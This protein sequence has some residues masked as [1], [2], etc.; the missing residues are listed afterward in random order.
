[1]ADILSEGTNGDPVAINHA[2]FDTLLADHQLYH[3]DLQMDSFITGRNG[4]TVYGCYKQALRELFKRYRGLK[5][6][7]VSRQRLAI[8]IE[9]LEEKLPATE[10]RYAHRRVELDLVEKRMAIEDC[11]KT[12]A[13]TEREFCRFLG[14]CRSLKRQIGELT[15][16]RRA[17]LDHEL[18]Q[19]KLREMAAVDWLS[20]GRL[21]DTVITFVA[22]LP[23]TERH[24]LLT[25]ILQADRMVEWYH[26]YTPA[27]PAPDTIA[28]V[29]HALCLE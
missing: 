7:Y 28:E 8:D 5:E 2:E 19:Y 27:L 11:A 14:Q 17:A 15:P 1:M 16:E 9:E 6:L 18:W 12:I 22:Y 4:G 23:P 25:E 10:D 20:R 21:G 29:P 3:S 13:D 26:N 24:E